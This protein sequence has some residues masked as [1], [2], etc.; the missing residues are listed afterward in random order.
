[1]TS[2]WLGLMALAYDFFSLAKFANCLRKICI[3][4]SLAKFANCLRKICRHFFF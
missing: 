4:F 1:M 3:F 2:E